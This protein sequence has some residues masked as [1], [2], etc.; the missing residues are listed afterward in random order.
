MLRMLSA[1][2]HWPALRVVLVGVTDEASLMSLLPTEVVLRICQ[3]V[4]PDAFTR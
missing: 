2:I 3:Y 1:R 4:A